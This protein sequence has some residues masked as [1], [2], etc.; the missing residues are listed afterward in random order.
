MC[1]DGLTRL[2][3]Q[4][5]VL[6]SLAES[7]AL[8]E[9]QCSYTFKIREAL[10]SDG[11]PVTAYD[12]EKS[13]KSSL[14]PSF[15]CPSAFAFYPIKNAQLAKEGKISVEEVGVKALDAKTLYVEL[16]HPHPHFLELASQPWYYPYT[17]RIA[18]HNQAFLEKK[19]DSYLS[20]GPFTIEY[21]K[22]QHVL[23]L[24]KNHSYWDEQAVQLEGIEVFFVADQNTELSMYD[25]G[26]IDWAGS[27][28]STLPIE[29]M[30]SL[31]PRKDFASYKVPGLY[32]YVF[33]TQNFPVNN[34]NIRK[35]LTLA[36]D[37][38]AL[39][40]HVTQMD[41]EPAT[42]LVP[43]LLKPL[44]RPYFQDGDIEHAQEFFRQGCE[45]LGLTPESFPTLTLSYNAGMT[46]HYKVVQAIQHQWKEALG[47]KTRLENL[48][49]KVY[50]DALTRHQFQVARLGVISLCSDPGYFL[51]LFAYQDGFGNYTGWY[52]PKFEE[53]FLQSR[54]AADENTRLGFIQDAEELFLDEMPIA[55]LFFYTNS[56]LKKN[57]VK[58]VVLYN[59]QLDFK[60]TKIQ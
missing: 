5:E 31:K 46:M 21:Y 19:T 37:R 3:P 33:N 14:N 18:A 20:I 10:W 6:L 13:W 56:Y 27:P 36:I 57:Y 34:A 39:I 11:T 26:D 4:G 28:C 52:N 2:S 30:L 44:E 50:L 38:Q 25:Q 40:E 51:E 23:S 15:P 43:T 35:A 22:P 47:V 41:M 53:L 42:R 54:Y 49:W 8:S 55:P 7:Y 9:D 32:Y 16:R 12:F 29:A 48:E 1:C 60:W 45:E 17:E 58:D 59:N 24:K